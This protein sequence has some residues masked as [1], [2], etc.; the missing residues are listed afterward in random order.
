MRRKSGACPRDAPNE[1]TLIERGLT[2]IAMMI[3]F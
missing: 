2:M 3:E 1:K